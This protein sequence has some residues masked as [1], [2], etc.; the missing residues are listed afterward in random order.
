MPLVALRLSLLTER[1]S[2]GLISL[3]EQ[4]PHP[5]SWSPLAD[6]FTVATAWGGGARRVSSDREAGSHVAPSEIPRWPLLLLTGADPVNKPQAP[7]GVL[8]RGDLI[9]GGFGEGVELAVVVGAEHLGRLAAPGA[10]SLWLAAPQLLADYVATELRRA[11]GG[12][13]PLRR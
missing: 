6:G 3:A 10:W 9:N 13:G 5:I 1:E 12:T 8:V 4:S 2:W 11:T 7:R